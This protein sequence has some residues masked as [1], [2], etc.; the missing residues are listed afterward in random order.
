MKTSFKHIASLMLLWA[1]F[2]CYNPAI[3]FG[4][5]GEPP[6][7]PG[8]HGQTG[9]QPPGGGAP[10]GNGTLLLLMTSAIYGGYKAW[11]V[12]EDAL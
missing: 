8:E 1:I 10:L 5:N 3:I 11:R 7:P 2:V 12:K 4:Q 6:P 9:N